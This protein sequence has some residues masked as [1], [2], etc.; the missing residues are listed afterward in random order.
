VKRPASVGKRKRVQDRWETAIMRD[1]CDDG[2]FHS[3][4][5]NRVD[6]KKFQL[7]DKVRVCVTLLSR[8]RRGGGK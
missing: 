1:P 3:L 2:R 8:D 7:G 4:I 6:N 5:I